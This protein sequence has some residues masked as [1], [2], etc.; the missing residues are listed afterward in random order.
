[1][2][3]E[4]LNASESTRITSR[5][6]LLTINLKEGRNLVIRDRCGKNPI[7]PLLLHMRTFT[8]RSQVVHNNREVHK[9]DTYHFTRGQLNASHFP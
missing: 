9:R 8:A 6:Y 2:G 7:L 3:N 4:A 5:S 1:M